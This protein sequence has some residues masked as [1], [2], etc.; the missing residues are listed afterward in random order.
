M[1][2]NSLVELTDSWGVGLAVWSV[3]TVLHTSLSK[4][5]QGGHRPQPLPASGLPNGPL[6]P[7][8]L[9]SAWSPR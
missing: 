2:L 1:K 5:D 8:Q 6:L 3:L 7:M 9:S 4:V